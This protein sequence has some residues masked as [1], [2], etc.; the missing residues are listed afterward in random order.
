LLPLPSGRWKAKGETVVL[1][2]DPVRSHVVR[3]IYDWYVHGEMRLLA[4][5]SRLNSEGVSAPLSLR[6]QGRAAWTKGTLWAILRNP[7]YRGILVYGKA[8]YSE[9][10][11]KRSKAP[12]L[13]AERI[14]VSGAVPGIVD[15]GVW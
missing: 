14:S 8:R 15:D 3:D 11:R 13:P 12:R 6:R 5:A 4:I 2:E 10:G 9:I 1:A 7:L